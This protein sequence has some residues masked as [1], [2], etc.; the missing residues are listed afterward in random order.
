[1]K[2]AA[3][4]L[5]AVNVTHTPEVRRLA[6]PHAG[7]VKPAQ[8]APFRRLGIG[9]GG[10]SEAAL[11]RLDDHVQHC[12]LAASNHLQTA[13]RAGTSSV[14]SSTRSPWAWQLLARAA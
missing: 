13:L 12:R 4:E 7:I 8:N 14:G 5:V 9:V 3:K 10:A 2:T 6:S 11:D 1:M